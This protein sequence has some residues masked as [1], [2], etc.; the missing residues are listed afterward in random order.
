MKFA[1]TI[2]WLA[3]AWGVLVVVAMYFIY[4]K[5][6]KYPRPPRRIRSSTMASWE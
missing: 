1:K 3:G 2:F 6:G 4:G 5:V